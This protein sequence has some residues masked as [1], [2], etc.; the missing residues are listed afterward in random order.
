MNTNHNKTLQQAAKELT[1]GNRAKACALIAQ[2]L[3]ANPQHDQAWIMFSY[4]LDEPEKQRYALRRALKINPANREAQARLDRLEPKAPPSPAKP[5]PEEL[6]PAVEAPSPPT[7]PPSKSREAR[8]TAVELSKPRATRAY[9][10]LTRARIRLTA[11]AKRFKRDWVIFSQS[12]LAIL[13]LILIFIFGLMAISHPILLN[14]V[15]PSGVY[16]PVTGFDTQIFTHPSMPS[17]QHLLGTDTL[18]RDVLSMILAATQSTF[19]VGLTAALMTALV[20]T[21]LS[22]LAAYFQGRVDSV[23]TN[24]A[25]VFLLFPAPIIM[26]IIGARFRDL[27]PVHLGLIYGFVTGAGATTIV[28]RSHGLQVVAKPFM[29]AARIAGGG[30]FHI[31]ITHMLP[32]MLP[33][34]ALQMMVAVT[35]AV[36]ADGFISFFG[37]TRNVTSWG[38]IIYDA[39]VYGSA[40]G[41]IAES[42]NMLVPASICFSLFALGF[43]LVSRG[44]HRVASPSLR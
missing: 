11:L 6:P 1:K 4:A 22:V 2:Y 3:Q 23:I 16:D 24:L 7:H 37:L 15:W 33:L 41:D 17:K 10:P 25:D 18:G 13:G 31:I 32:S 38:T 34:A 27:K 19:V 14:T 40:V 43:Y 39:L 21:T 44:L 9:N 36:V 42:W 28:M 26:I 20:G 35:G 8:K 30:P 29:S 12:K 5:R